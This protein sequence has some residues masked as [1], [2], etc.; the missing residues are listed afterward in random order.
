MDSKQINGY[1]SQANRLITIASKYGQKIALKAN[2]LDE[3]TAWKVKD[4]LNSH[5]GGSMSALEHSIN[6]AKRMF[7][8]EVK[9]FNTACRIYGITEIKDPDKLLT[10]LTD[11]SRRDFYRKTIKKAMK[12]QAIYRLQD[13]ELSF[14]KKPS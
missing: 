2:L 9:N 13:I 14:T 8:V 4:V 11:S 12:T 3:S 5:Y 1:W 7:N 10:L 6:S